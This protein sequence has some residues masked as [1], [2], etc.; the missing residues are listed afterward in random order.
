VSYTIAAAV[1]VAVGVLASYVPSVRASR[2][3]PMIVLRCE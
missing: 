3:D 2:A 1:L